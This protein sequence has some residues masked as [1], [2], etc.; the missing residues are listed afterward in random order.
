MW[1]G[2]ESL[3]DCVT[4]AG[5]PSDT[6]VFDPLLCELS[7]RN[8]PKTKNPA[9]F[10]RF[11]CGVGGN[12]TPDTGIFSPLL[13]QLSYRTNY[14]DGKCIIY[15]DFAKLDTR[16]VAATPAKSPVLALYRL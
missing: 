9:V 4:Q 7:K 6:G 15:P 1:C 2:R 13:Y 5:N 8:F 3:P 16:K 11:V 14:W 12:R 10:A